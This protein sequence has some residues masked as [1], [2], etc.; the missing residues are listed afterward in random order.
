MLTD[1]EIQN[2]KPREK[3]YKLSDGDGLHLEVSPAGGKMRTMANGWTP[4]RRAW[5][6]VL[7]RQ[8]RPWGQSTGPTSEVG[9]ARAARRATRVGG[10][11]G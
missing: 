1:K 5:Q 7:I 6:A 10:G 9:K 2:A 3:A 11:S 8:W 4:E